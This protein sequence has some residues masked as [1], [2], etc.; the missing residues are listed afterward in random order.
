MVS[1]GGAVE[2]VDYI[3]FW[4]KKPQGETCV[5]NEKS[6]ILNGRAAK[7]PACWMMKT[8]IFII[9]HAGSFA[10]LPFKVV[11]FFRSYFV[12]KY[13]ALLL[14]ILDQGPE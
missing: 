1:V 5:K 6:T 12:H 14:L 13:L 9:Q 3:N 4:R 2:L 11:L 7:E 10:A 8:H